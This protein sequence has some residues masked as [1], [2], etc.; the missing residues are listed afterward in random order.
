MA[1]QCPHCGTLLPRDDARFCNHCGT[2]LPD[3]V[4]FS[5][6]SSNATSS[7]TSSPQE[8][9]STAH[10]AE[11]KPKLREQIAQQPF[12]RSSQSPVPPEIPLWI[13]KLE[14]SDQKG[15]LPGISGG[16]DNQTLLSGGW[17]AKEQDAVSEHGL[18]NQ[19]AR[20][21]EAIN[22]LSTF[23]PVPPEKRQEPLSEANGPA[24]LT[25]KETEPAQSSSEKEASISGTQQSLV[26]HEDAFPE[27]TEQQDS[28]ATITPSRAQFA[29]RE[30][31]VK[32]WEQEDTALQPFEE[33]VTVTEPDIVEDQP[34]RPL[35]SSSAPSEIPNDLKNAAARPVPMPGEPGRDQIELLDTVQ[36]TAYGQAKPISAGSPSITN[37]VDL[38][39]KATRIEAAAVQ[40]PL[41]KPGITP[42]PVQQREA[43]MPGITSQPGQRGISMPGITPQPVGQH[44]TSMPGIP[45]QERRPDMQQAVVPVTPP[46]QRARRRS[47]LIAVIV[48][49]P[50]LLLGGLAVWIVQAQPFSVSPVSQPW[51]KFQDEKLGVAFSYPNGWQAQVDHAKSTV[52]LAD[53]TNTAQ[54]TVAVSNA[55]GGDLAQYLS[56]Q[57]KQ[58]QMADAKSAT[59]ISF[60]H[61]SWTQVRGTTQQRGANYTTTLLATVHNNRLFTITLLAPSGNYADQEKTNF[62]YM[63]NSW[64]FL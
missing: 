42:L 36:I 46:L 31:R 7:N 41:S 39:E 37:Q 53:S 32:V 50:V 60:G 44:G 43:S 30:L 57:A 45:A 40:R 58:I 48:L 12:S 1:T 16:A 8:A 38:A 3:P 54:M 64:Q 21:E 6:S 13:E 55:P 17:Q 19:T 14:A 10:R 24:S 51:Q 2:S 5:Q 27:T 23:S 9:S 59:S 63:R 47:P 52:H 33:D 29:G 4:S 49:L 35:T 26:G 22:T 28:P 62:S 15:S 18:E 25:S 11:H 61:S 34:T 20:E 56:Q